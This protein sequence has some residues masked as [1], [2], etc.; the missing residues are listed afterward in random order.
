MFIKSNFESAGGGINLPDNINELIEDNTVFS[1]IKHDAA[2]TVGII[3]GS[4]F[5]LPD[6]IILKRF[7]YRGFLDSI[8]HRTMFNK[9]RRLWEIS[10]K[11]YA[12]GLPVPKP[13]A[14]ISS[15]GHNY[16][17]YLSG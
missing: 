8:L 14:Y 9:A 17:F 1:L 15:S 16:S 4:A 7:N 13:V 12:I 5:G 3:K 2:T 10:L 6:D 11:F